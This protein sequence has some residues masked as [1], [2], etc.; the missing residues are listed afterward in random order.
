MTAYVLRRLLWLPVLL[1][2]V[3]FATF[4]LARFGPGDPIAVIAGQVR[5][6][7]VIAQIRADR[8]LDR[9]IPQQYLTWLSRAVRGDLGESYAQRGFEV[10]ELIF[11]RMWIS[12]QLGLVALIIVFAVGVPLGLLAAR[13]AG[14]WMDPMIIGTLLFLQAIP[15]MVLI[16]PLIWMF[17]VKWQLLPVGGWDGIFALY[18]IAGVIAIPI[19][20]PHLYIPLVAFTLP[21]FVGVA[22]L[23]R[24]TALEVNLEDYVRT[25][26]SKGLSEMTVQFKHVLPNALLPLITVVGFALA[27]IIE[28][29]FF[30]ETLMGINGIGRM[31]FEAVTSRD[32]DVILATT[33]VFASAFVICNLIAEI[34]YGFVDPRVRIG[35]S[36]R[37]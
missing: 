15:V 36:S 37:S 26:R 35:G 21:G 16:P 24:I 9:P 7:V 1:L 20:N 34:V 23:V 5:D 31:T 4:A 13:L 32:Y 27:G 33:V 10:S 12:A 3:S 2:I 30:V 14:T 6:P 8:G 29:A 22:R 25:A 19:P 17:A 11:P 28:G 18:W